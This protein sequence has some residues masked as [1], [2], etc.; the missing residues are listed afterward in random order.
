MNKKD[1]KKLVLEGIEMIPGKIL[2]MADNLEIC[3][4]DESLGNQQLLGL[5]EGV[6]KTRRGNYGLSLPDKITI[7]K[8]PIERISSSDEKIRELVRRT[9]WHEI[10]HHFGMGEREVRNLERKKFKRSK[11]I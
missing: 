8:K 2:E 3:I 4:E 6:P 11:K 5:Y 1:F 10:A 9:V 7:F